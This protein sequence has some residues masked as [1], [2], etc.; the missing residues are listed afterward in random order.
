MGVACAAIVQTH[1][2]AGD[3]PGLPG[4]IGVAVVPPVDPLGA[5]TAWTGL[6][7]VGADF[8]FGVLTVFVRHASTLGLAVRLGTVIYARSAATADIPHP[9]STGVA[10]GHPQCRS[11]PR[12]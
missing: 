10:A 9:A 2:Q 3:V 1:V 5:S 11:L 6:R 8:C 7:L 4:V 12:H